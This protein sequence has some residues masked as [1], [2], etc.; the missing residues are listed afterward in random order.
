VVADWRNIPWLL[1]KSSGRLRTKTRRARMPYKRFSLPRDTFLVTQFRQ[2]LPLK[3]LFQQP[4]PIA[5][6]KRLRTRMLITFLSLGLALIAT[7]LAVAA[8][9][10]LSYSFKLGDLGI[11]LMMVMPL[12]AGVWTFIVS[13]RR[14]R[15]YMRD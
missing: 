13:V 8:T 9:L 1:K 2:F 6:V 7:A 14:L 10:L 4:L 11:L 15:T 3:G 12:V 5:Q